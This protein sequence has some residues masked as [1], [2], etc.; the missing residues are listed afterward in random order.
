MF[1]FLK[2]FCFTTTN[3]RIFRNYLCEMWNIIICEIRKLIFLGIVGQGG[4][5]F[6]GSKYRA[7]EYLKCPIKRKKAIIRI[8]PMVLSSPVSGRIFSKFSWAT[9][10]DISSL[11][12]V[13]EIR[14]VT[15]SLVLSRLVLSCFKRAWEC[16]PPL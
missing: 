13:S 4:F 8:S 12:T 1:L 11:V 9:R 7:Q 6:S 10:P 15:S 2:T 3:L 5:V 16:R 14:E